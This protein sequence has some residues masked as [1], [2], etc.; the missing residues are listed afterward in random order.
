MMILACSYGS[1]DFYQTC[2]VEAGVI[3]AGAIAAF[4]YPAVHQAYIL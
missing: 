3:E 1:I 4:P 2:V